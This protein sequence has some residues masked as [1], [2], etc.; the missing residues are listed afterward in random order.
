M[1]ERPPTPTYTQE[2]VTEILKRALKQQSLD[3]Q[4]LTHD[5]LVEMAGEVG[6]DRAALESATADL[7][8]SRANE[9]A[10]ESHTRELAEERAR[11]L[12]RFA[13]SLVTY[14]VVNAMLYFI[15]L[16]FTGGTW[17]YWVLLGWGLVLLVQLRRIFLAEDILAKRKIRELRRAERQQRR[18]W[19]RE[20][21]ARFQPHFGAGTSDVAAAGAREFEAAVQSGVAAL[22]SVAARKIQAH[23]ERT[24]AAGGS[25]ARPQRGR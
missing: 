25:V 7:A 18:A 19:K 23:A 14:V 5:E 8:Q 21:F 11:L 12:G 13:S 1:P 20:R 17:F 24:A 16:R 9:L 10:R 22:L 4:V 3:K 15:D 6:I 2:E